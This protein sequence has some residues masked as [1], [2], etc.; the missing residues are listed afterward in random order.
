MRK[1]TKPIRNIWMITREFGELAGAGGVK[2]VTV[3]LSRAMAAWSG[4][5]VHVVMPC[6]GFIDPEEQGFTL[7]PQSASS[8]TPLEFEV[9]MNYAGEERRETIKVWLARQERIYVYL[10]DSSRFREKRA[11]YSY[12]AEDEELNP[13]Q[14]HGVGHYDYFAMNLLLQKGAIQLMVLRGEKPDIIHCHDGHSAVLPAV[15]QETPWLKSLFQQTGFLV[16]VHNAGLGHHQDVAD[17]PYA[18]AMTGLP[19]RVIMSSL[20]NKSYN[21][22]ITAGMYAI[23]NTVSENYAKELQESEEDAQTGWLG[24]RLVDMGIRL[25]GVTNGIDPSAFDPKLGEKIGLAASYDLLK[26]ETMAGKKQC[27]K[28]LIAE[29]SNGSGVG[30]VK[31]YGFLAQEQNSPLLTFIGRLSTQK[32]IDILKGTA[33]EMLERELDFSLVILGSGTAEV[34]KGLIELATSTA[35]RG[36]ICF[37]SGYDPLL[38]NR[39]FSGGD[40]FLVPS[41]YEPCGLTDFIAQLFGNLPIV[42]HVGGLVK[43]QDER[44]GFAY[45]GNSVASLLGATLRAMEKIGDHQGIRQMQMDAVKTIGERYTWKVVKDDYLKLYQRA[46]EQRLAG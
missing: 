9:D 43:V 30:Q 34:E 20:L 11:V 14:L 38:A 12:T 15:I 17:L 1:Y 23:M 16:T 3:Q 36:K 31:Q 10:L 8:D 22:L 13:E 29:L 35:A 6:Y 44:T 2:D 21:P 41:R 4:R 39:V 5:N 33:G 24:H 18:K 27:K 7:L 26:D 32:G 28:A 45:R 37:L 42:H 25:E 19:E 40:F 46:I